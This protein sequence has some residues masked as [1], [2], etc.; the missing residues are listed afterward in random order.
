[1]FVE[2]FNYVHIKLIIICYCCSQARWPKCLIREHS[3]VFSIGW[4]ASTND[5]NNRQ[6]PARTYNKSIV[7]NINNL[8]LQC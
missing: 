5:G 8:L 1:M 3:G 2:T 7:T 6:G 4:M